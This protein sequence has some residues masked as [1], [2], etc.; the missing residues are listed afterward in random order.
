M[1]KGICYVHPTTVHPSDSKIALL[2]SACIDSGPSRLCTLICATAR[3]AIQ[4][5]GGKAFNQLVKFKEKY[6]QTD[7]NPSSYTKK[8]KIFRPAL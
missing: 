3:Y 5:L 2:S 8:L 1:L 6:S 7:R 4:V